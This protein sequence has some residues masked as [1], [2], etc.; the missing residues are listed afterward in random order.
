MWPILCADIPPP[1]S[2]WSRSTQSIDIKQNNKIFWLI[3]G[4]IQ[5]ALYLSIR[6][7]ALTSD[8]NIPTT[9]VKRTTKRGENRSKWKE[10]WENHR[11]STLNASNKFK[12]RWWIMNL[13]VDTITINCKST[14]PCRFIN[15]RLGLRSVCGHKPV[16]QLRQHFIVLETHARDIIMMEWWNANALKMRHKWE[17]WEVRKAKIQEEIL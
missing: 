1:P 2:V 17:Y 12:T 5:C 14:L 9:S 15:I 6:P 13:L 4:E 3:F 7:K 16:E 10:S 11:K 8:M